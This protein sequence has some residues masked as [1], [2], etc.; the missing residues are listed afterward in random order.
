M[1]Q[2]NQEN[3][4]VNYIV[5]AKYKKWLGKRD[6]FQTFPDELLAEEEQIRDN[7]DIR[8][9]LGEANT[10]SEELTTR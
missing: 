7:R 2:A 4:S 3:K 10:G 1:D 6:L 5:D 9:V 8:Q